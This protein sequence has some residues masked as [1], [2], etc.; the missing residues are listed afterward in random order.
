[1]AGTFERIHIGV[2][3]LLS[4]FV[5]CSLA[6]NEDEVYIIVLVSVCMCYKVIPAKL[7]PGMCRHFVSSFVFV[8]GLM[9]TYRQVCMPFK[10]DLA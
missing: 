6:V 3:V 2:I 4:S 1:M 9:V 5:L 8:F 7:V 10:C